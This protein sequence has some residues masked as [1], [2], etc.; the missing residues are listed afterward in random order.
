MFL[1]KKSVTK[2]DLD[3]PSQC[4]KCYNFCYTLFFEASL[5]L[6][7]IVGRQSPWWPHLITEQG[8]LFTHLIWER[9]SISQVLI[10]VKSHVLSLTRAR[11]SYPVLTPSLFS[12]RYIR[13]ERIQVLITSVSSSNH[14]YLQFNLTLWLWPEPLTLHHKVSQSVTKC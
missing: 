5:R 13:E 8:Q 11:I 2:T 7:L 14:S 12:D 10:L 3:P 9:S 6:G 4:I 1:K